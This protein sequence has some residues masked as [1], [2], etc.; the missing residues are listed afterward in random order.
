MILQINDHQDALVAT[1]QVKEAN[2]TVSE[3]FKAELFTQIDG[4]SKYIVVNFEEVTYVDSSFLGALVSALKHAITNKAE[5]VVAGLNK[6]ILGLFR[7]I[8][9]DK[10]F[11]IFD[12]T[13]GALADKAK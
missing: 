8:R 13:E 6:D 11:K 5:I 1:I 4:G 7:L 2:L 12:T 3:K 9:L 10:A